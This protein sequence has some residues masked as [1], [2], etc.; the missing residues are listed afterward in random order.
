MKKQ[1]VSSTKNTAINKPVLLQLSPS[2]LPALHYG[3][4]TLSVS[5]LCSALQAAGQSVAVITTTA[6]GAQE[7][8]VA[9][10]QA[11]AVAGVDC[12]YYPRWTK[13][14]SHFS[15]A[16]L[17]A[18]WRRLPQASVVHIHSWWNLVVMPAV[19]LCRLRGI[20]PVLSPRGMLSPYTLRS[21]MKRLFHRWIGR[22]LL[23]GTILHA[24]SDQEA[25]E[26]LAVVPGWQYFV[27]PNIIELA[28]AGKCSPSPASAVFRLIFLSRVHPKKGLEQLF[29]VLPQ[30]NFPWHLQIIGQGETAYLEQLQQQ[31]Q[32]LGLAEKVSWLG[33]REGDEKFQLLAEA[34]LFVLP[35]QNENF[36]NAALEALS[37]GTPVLLSAQVGL[38]AYVREQTLGWIYDG[39]EA[40]LLQALHTAQAE[41]DQCRT[42]R[43][44]A[45]LQIQADFGAEKIAQQYLRAYQNFGLL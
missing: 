32:Q 28:P 36:A 44:K 25:A 10:G 12:W 14:H 8:A 23:R 26:A 29:S 24:T 18:F 30:L 13:D 43:E 38:S 22:W 45:P 42:I 4:P 5:R 34:D 20:K 1:P 2:Y 41:K 35:S 40:G 11:I 6:N 39:T 17:W 37:A 7:L 33:W 31:L 9:Q 3:G 21:P 19:F 15:P 16:L 27:L